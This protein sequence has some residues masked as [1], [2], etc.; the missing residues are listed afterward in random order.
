MRRRAQIVILVA[1][2]VLTTQQW[3]YAHNTLVSLQPETQ[4]DA[5][6]LSSSVHDDSPGGPEISIAEVTFSGSLQM[7]T[8]EQ[9]QIADSIKQKTHGTS[10]D[11]VTDEALERAREGWQDRGY[12]NVEVSGDTRTLIISPITQQIAL[13]A[14]V[15]EG[16]QYNLSGIAFKNNKAFSNLESL[17]G[18]FPIKDGDIFSREKIGKGLENLRKAYGELGYINFTS[19]PDTRV[20]DE[21]KLI[22][23]EIDFDEG[24][25]FRVGRVNVL[26][27]DKPARQELLKALAMKAGQV[28][29]SRL[30]EQFLLMHASMIPDC[31]CPDRQRKHLDDKSGI[32]TLTF[33]F[34]PCSTE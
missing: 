28:Y 23:L 11:D 7:H 18:L 31:E 21:N 19:V 2:W 33:D 12:F 22:S 32:V 3:I 20:D 25:Q 27:L 24:K 1:A 5:S 6:C 15:Q 8:S 4:S 10:L 30:W 17:R 9:S 16:A 14:Q 34:R 13:T 26:G 29:S